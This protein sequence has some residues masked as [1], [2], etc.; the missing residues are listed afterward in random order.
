[1]PAFPDE[2]LK[3][4]QTGLLPT[5]AL[6]AYLAGLVRA[7]TLVVAATLTASLALKLV[8]G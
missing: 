6:R 1:M 7:A 5:L 2:D 4:P 8:L 3:T